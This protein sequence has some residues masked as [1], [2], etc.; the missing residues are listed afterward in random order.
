VSGPIFHTFAQRADP[1]RTP[2]LKTTR[3][4][5]VN[6]NKVK[7]RYIRSKVLPE[8]QLIRAGVGGRRNSLLDDY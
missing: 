4:V 3:N 8:K 2:L 6:E 7:L 5:T 1:L